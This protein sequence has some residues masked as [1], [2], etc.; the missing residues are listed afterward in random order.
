M[1]DLPHRIGSYIVGEVLGEG[2]MGTV[3][4]AEQREPIRRTV[5]LKVLKTSSDSE[6][7]LARYEIER[8]ALAVMDHPSIAKVFD[9]GI[10]DDGSPYVV[11]ERVDGTPIGRYC[12]E[13]RLTIRKRVRLFA[14]VCRAIQ[15]AH[16]KG[17][18]H[19]DLK[20]AHVLVSDVD[21]RPLPRIIDFG[22]AMALE[23][24]ERPE[25]PPGEPLEVAGTPGYMS[26]EQIEGSA[27]IDTRTDIYSLGVMLYELLAG[28]LPYEGARRGGWAAIAAQI[29]K[30][31]TLAERLHSLDDTQR[32][33]AGHRSTTPRSLRKELHGDLEWIVAR[34]MA[35]DRSRRYET[36][37]ELSLE[38]E[39]YLAFE[40]VQA[41][42]GGATYRTRRF[43]RR[44]R[45][46]VVF[47]SVVTLG[48]AA[49]GLTA[50]IQAARIARA[51][52]EAETRRTQ[53]EVLIDFMLSEFWGTLETVGRLD[54]RDSVGGRAL[55]YFAQV[56]LD[57]YSEEELSSRAQALYQIGEVRLEQGRLPEAGEAFEQSLRFA[58]DL[59][60]RRPDNNDWLFG[61]GQAE[62]WVGEGLR[63]Q[64]D[65]EQALQHFE[66]YRVISLELL[67]REP[68]RRTYQLEVGYSH[69]NIGAILRAHG[70]FQ[71]AR[72][73]FAASLVIKEQVAEGDPGSQARRYDVGQGHNTLGT[74]LQQMGR[75]GEARTHFER[76][77]AT[78]DSLVEESSENA[79]YRFRLGVSHDFLG[80]VKHAQGDVL[81]AR[82][83]FASER[84]LMEVLTEG[85]PT[86]LR[87]MRNLAVTEMVEA[88]ALYDLQDLR[89]ALRSAELAIGRQEQIVEQ[90][91]NQR[92]WRLDLGRAY[93]Q[94]GHILMAMGRLEDAAA[95]ASEAA[96][97]MEEILLEEAGRASHEIDLARAMLLVGEI[98]RAQGRD[99]RA[100]EQ[101]DSVIRRLTPLT[102]DA[103]N[104]DVLEPLAT[105]LAL[106][107]RPDDAI[108]LVERLQEMGYGM[109]ELDRIRE[110]A[111]GVAG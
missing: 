111:R 105:A 109:P 51:R 23:P 84:E 75:L 91:P 6:R 18:I 59:S 96:S 42:A 83:H 95:R 45:V 52:D 79:G 98:L 77:L 73:Q 94:G 15:H 89:E 21:G 53:A 5:A 49:Y 9:A 69:T 35:K 80:R 17:V 90:N 64:G 100:R 81:G 68:D 102:S 31:P 12:D 60:G 30:V 88:H 72:E 36:A 54:M 85:D 106:V 56:P 34:A 48:L 38:L 2:G 19:R 4:L 86:N 25:V 92:Q 47:G 44:H 66:T 103:T 27:D 29:Q 39:R 74:I 37:H 24:E 32:T 71:G 50:T 41:K 14:E 99:N 46:G 13:R 28:A 57:L 26:P 58:R 76:D 55:A 70:D 62:F 3:Y 67:R 16:Q 20:P 11:M 61:L 63:R 7:V 10:T 97:L 107:G 87:W 8:Q 22:I 108:Q 78:K 40:P 65:S 82:Q 104:V 110:I 101:F 33:V 93:R 43:V 1:N